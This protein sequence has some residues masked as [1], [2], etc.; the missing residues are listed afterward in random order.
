MVTYYTALGRLVTKEKDGE[1]IPVV[2]IDDEEFYISV[3]ELFVWGSLHWNFLNKEDLKKEYCRRKENAHMF[4]DN[5]FEQT[6]TRL[7]QRKLVTCATEYLAVDALYGLVSQLKIRPIRFNVQ[8]K[9]KSFA[10]LY[11]QKG[12][13]FT[14]CVRTFFGTQITPNEKNVL[15]LSERVGVT[16]AELIQCMEKDIRHLGTEENVVEKLYV[17][18]DT[19]EEQLIRA[20]R[21]SY[22]K[23][24]ILQAVCNLY[25]K[26]KIVFE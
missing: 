17:K 11:F 10:Y 22:L 23:T 26:K 2:I 4:C 1:R 7:E 19:T 6:L 24:N 3:E 16:A 21:F 8:D 13:P 25:L 18:D 20:S 5:S 15:K 12:V 9:L 14:N